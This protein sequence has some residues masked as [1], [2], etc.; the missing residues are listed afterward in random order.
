MTIDLKP[1][2]FCGGKAKILVKHDSLLGDKYVP[3]CANKNCIGR[4]YRKYINTRK[5]VAEWNRR[6]EDQ[7]REDT[8]KTPS[9]ISVNDRLPDG[10]GTVLIV[11]YGVV[12]IAFYWGGGRFEAPNGIRHD[13]GDDEFDIHYWMPLPEPPKEGTK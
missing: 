9:W 7:F 1:C 5:A 4:V 2:P 6:I 12:S 10:E 8:K 11:L 3:T 13:A